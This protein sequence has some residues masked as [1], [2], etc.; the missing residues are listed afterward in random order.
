MK[1]SGDRLKALLLE[2]NLT[3][4]DFAAQR[5]VSSQHVNNWFKRGVPQ[6]RL[7]EI[8]DLFC[9]RRRWLRSGEGPK[10]PTPLAPATSAAPNLALPP[11]LQAL[12]TDLTHL[13]LHQVRDGKLQVLPGHYQPIPRRALEWV[14]VNAEKAICLGMPGNN[15][16]PLLPQG[17]LLAI[18]RGCTRVVEGECYA[19]LHN[20][21]LRVQHLTLGHNGTLC[22][23][24]HD[25]LN[26]PSERYTAYQRRVQNLE[27]LGWVF[28]WSSLRPARPG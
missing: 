17:A 12:D 14:Q 25:R 8:A 11:P 24:S 13:P 22:L 7:D 20:G 28:W 21:R 27:I 5:K 19:L 2:C 16:A 1:T 4:S 23:H 6:A 18:D 10:H 26:H 3:P 9:V 15:M